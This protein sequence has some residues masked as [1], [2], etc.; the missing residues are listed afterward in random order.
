ML[1]FNDYLEAARRR[2]PHFFFEYI[3]G[4]S[5]DEIT[6]RAN[7]AQLAATPLRQRLMKDVSGLTPEIDLF[8][9]KQS[10]PIVLGPVGLAGMMAR[11][12]EVQAARAAVRMG[13]PY[14]MS[15]YSICSM[16]EVGNC[17]KAPFWYQLNMFKDRVFMQELLQT[18]SQFCSALIFNI[19]LPVLGTR[20][21]D[22]RSGLAGAALRNRLRRGLQVVSRPAW[23]W[24]VGL[25]GLPHAL[26][27]IQPY[28]DSR[29]LKEDSSVWTKANLDPAATWQDLAWVRE[30][31][32]GPLIIKGVLDPEDARAAIDIGATGIVVS[33][34]GGRQLDSVVSTASAL[35]AI[36][37]CVN[38]RATIFVDGGV[39]SGIDVL[40][41]LTLGADAVFLGRAWVNALAAAGED[42][43]VDLLTNMAGELRVAMAMTGNR[44][45]KEVRDES[46]QARSHS[47]RPVL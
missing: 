32:T 47:S 4:G 40:K 7:L 44:T 15:T 34:H 43:V 27:N 14:C 39:R 2:L 18:A 6:L 19:D 28:M 33:N 38:G 11:R 31:W 1:I 22:F 37:E 5:Y 12:G 30:N 29:G 35:P 10:L 13:I 24:D 25:R 46:R 16:S 21:R 17:I 42:G 9:K 3:N 41:M 20:Y 26:G 23:S 8:G 45:L 36:A